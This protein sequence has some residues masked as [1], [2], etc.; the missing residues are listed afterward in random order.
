MVALS[1]LS[2]ARLSHVVA[3]AAALSSMRARL[4]IM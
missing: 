1:S 2:V 3:V 4:A